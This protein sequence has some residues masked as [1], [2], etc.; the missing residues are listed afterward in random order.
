MGI[1]VTDVDEQHIPTI[2]CPRCHQLFPEDL[3][4]CPNC[5]VD[6]LRSRQ[7]PILL[8]LAGVLMLVFAIVMMFSVM[9]HSEPQIALADNQQQQDDQ[10]LPASAPELTPRPP[11]N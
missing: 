5:H 6:L 7:K 9:H 11:L 10:E 1:E 2:P 4:T 3:R 8:G